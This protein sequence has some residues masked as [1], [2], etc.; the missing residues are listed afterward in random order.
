MM[1]Y[2]SGTT[3]RPK[4]VVRPIGATVEQTLTAM[5]GYAHSLGLTAADRTW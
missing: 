3:G 5:V 1:L 2:T 4:G